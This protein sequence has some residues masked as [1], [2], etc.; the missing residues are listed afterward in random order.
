VD[1]DAPTQR[2]HGAVN[3]G[4]TTYEEVAIFFLDHADAV[5]QPSVGG[6]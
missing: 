5:P 2:G 6:L 4:K 1:W 3:V